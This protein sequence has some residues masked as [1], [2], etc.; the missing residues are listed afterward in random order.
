MSGGMEFTEKQRE[1]TELQFRMLYEKDADL[2][3]T[4]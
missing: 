4:L 1:T 3:K 2:R